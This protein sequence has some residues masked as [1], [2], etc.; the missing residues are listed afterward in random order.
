MHDHR[1]DARDI[2]P[3][4]Y[5]ERR[6]W[7]ALCG[8]HGRAYYR[9]LMAPDGI[10]V[11]PGMRLDRDAAIEAIPDGPSWTSY[12]LRDEDVHRPSPDTAVVA[13]HAVARRDGSMYEA[14]ATSTYVL[15]DGRWWL[16]L[17]QQSPVAAAGS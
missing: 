12:E 9:A 5:L 11:F 17:H 7:D 8:A 14:E 4:L 1:M 16:A 3:L 10:M 2:D 6:G 15:Q 13:Y